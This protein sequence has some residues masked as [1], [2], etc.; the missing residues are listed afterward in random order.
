MLL[1]RFPFV[2]I[3]TTFDSYKVNANEEEN[4]C[5]LVV[6]ISKFNLED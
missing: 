5:V 4:L 1:Q 6:K 3:K 2:F